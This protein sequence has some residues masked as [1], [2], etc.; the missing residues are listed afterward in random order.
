MRTLDERWAAAHANGTPELPLL[1]ELVSQQDTDDNLYN[2]VTQLI[3]SALAHL[4][5]KDADKAIFYAKRDLG[6]CR[7][8]LDC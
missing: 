1:A 5:K 2:R 7:A 4:E 3:C 6:E 8:L